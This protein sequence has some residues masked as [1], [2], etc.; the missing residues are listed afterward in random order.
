VV[1]EGAELAALIASS[2]GSGN[3]YVEV[4]RTLYEYLI[5]RGLYAGTV[6]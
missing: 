5:V 2:T 3:L 1:I 4:A 6:Q